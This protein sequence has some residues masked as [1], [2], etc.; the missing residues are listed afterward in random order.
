VFGSF[1]LK[2]NKFNGVVV[3]VWSQLGGQAKSQL[4]ALVSAMATGFHA[5]DLKLILVIPPPIGRTAFFD[6]DDFASLASVVDGFSLMT[7]DFS[8]SGP[9]PNAPLQWM[10][11][12]VETLV[13]QP[14]PLRKKILLGLNFYGYDFSSGPEAVIGNRYI[15]LLSKYKPKIKWSPDSSEHYF[16]YKS[17]GSSHQVYYPTLKSIQLRIDLAQELGTGLSIWEVGQGLDYFYDLL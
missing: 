17:G 13:P 15:D 5:N 9:G 1:P 6:S 14:G 12:C 2:T 8:A 4:S 7:Y 11:Q 3:E 16:E 10:K